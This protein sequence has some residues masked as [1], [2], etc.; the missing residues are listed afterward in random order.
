[1]PPLYYALLHFWLYFA[2]ETPFALRLLSV[3]LSLLIV[4]LVNVVAR[5]GFGAVAG[6]FAA[7]FTALAPFQVYHAQE[8]RMYT[9]L[10]LSLLLYIYGVM[11]V[12]S[13]TRGAPVLI[14]F[15]T[16]LALYSHNLAFLTLIAAN[17]Y[18]A[19][20]RDWMAQAYLIAGQCVGVLVFV[21]WL[22]YVPGQI[23]KIQTAFWTQPPG[24]VEILQLLVVFTTHLP[25]PSILFAG[26][27][28]V[29]LASFVVA[30]VESA[31]L[32]RHCVPPM[33]GLLLVFA[34]IPPA[35]MFMLSYVMRPIFV[36]RGVIASSLAYYI[37]LAVLVSRA[38]RRGRVAIALIAVGV[39]G[40]TLPFL[41]TSWG[42]WRRAPFAEADRFLRAQIQPG[43]LILHDNKLAFF[44]MRFYDRALPQVFLADPPGSGND[45]LARATQEAMGLYSEEW[46]AV[47]GHPRIWFIIFQ[48]AI[49][50]AEQAGHPHGNVLRLDAMMQR[51]KMFSF[52]DLRIIQYDAH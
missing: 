40:W 16:A 9:I 30:V 6:T 4:G 29:T 11:R 47:P 38:P 43:D 13:R 18:F 5:R 15:A 42:E 17:V 50:E 28:F 26:A 3:A 19:W 34:L 7:G 24:V 8:L 10:G 2:G 49:D 23:S 36:P 32:L 25:L 37:L 46:T 45:T 1:M 52:G 33:F 31:R 14:A 51:G 44:P 41:V 48:T 22:L 20:K 12:S 27:L 21:P 39:A 35:L